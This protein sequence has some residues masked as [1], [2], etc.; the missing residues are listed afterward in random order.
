MKKISCLLLTSVS[1]LFGL[2]TLAHSI[3][4]EEEG[5]EFTIRYGHVEKNFEEYDP[6]KVERVTAFDQSGNPINLEMIPEGEKMVL[7]S[8]VT[9]AL[10][11]VAF[12]N[13]YWVETAE[14]W[15]N[16]SK[17]EV[18]NYI[19]SSHTYKYTKALYNWSSSFQQPVGLPLEIIPLSNPM[20]LQPGQKLDVQILYEQ[21]PLSRLKVTYNGADGEIIETD[22]NGI[23]TITLSN[24]ELHYLEANH[25]YAVENNPKTDAVA[26]SSTLT[27]E[28]N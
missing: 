24:S 9:P 11:A 16:I 19:S 3:W 12:N 18:D 27:F 6:T 26:H 10:V 20:N 28:L 2:P 21:E 14:G 17:Q 25:R 1:L 13:G 8:E 22:Q 5:E 15:E 7:K 4:L 23:A